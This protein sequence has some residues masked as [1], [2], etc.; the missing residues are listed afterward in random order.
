MSGNIS[1]FLRIPRLINN[2]GSKAKSEESDQSIPES[3]A[4][5]EG[6]RICCLLEADD[7]AWMD[8][9]AFSISS[10]VKASISS[11]FEIPRK[12]LYVIFCRYN[13]FCC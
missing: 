3:P 12:I 6:E 13:F 10:F 9:A 7:V 4:V 5:F 1:I 2:P 11:R 8:L